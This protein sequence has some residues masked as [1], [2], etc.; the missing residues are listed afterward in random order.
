MNNTYTPIAIVADDISAEDF[1]QFI[2]EKYKNES[3]SASIQSQTKEGRSALGDFL[4]LVMASDLISDLSKNVLYD[5]LK[6]GFLRLGQIFG[7]KPMAIIKM[8]NGIETRIP[9]SLT[10]EDIRSK[11]IDVLLE[12]D[13]TSIHFDS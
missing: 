6:F 9:G 7:S 8:K 5:V 4:V 12:G 10:N 11:I 3:L 2:N 1:L 13:I